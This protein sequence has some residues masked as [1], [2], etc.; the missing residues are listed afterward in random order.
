M[1]VVLKLYF[2]LRDV[3]RQFSPAI[4]LLHW[5]CCGREI[6]KKFNNNSK[7]MWLKDSHF[8]KVCWDHFIKFDIFSSFNDW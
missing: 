7:I 5:N 3:G 6:F 4:L 1:Q 2:V 8:K